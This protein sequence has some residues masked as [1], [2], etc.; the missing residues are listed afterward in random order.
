M[1]LDNLRKY[2]IILASNSPRRK[3]LLGGLGIDYEVKV[4]PG[5]D[6]SY[7]DSLKGEEIPV[8]IAS[9]KAAAYRAVMQEN[10][11]IITADTIVYLDGE[12]LGKP[13][14]AADAARMLRLLSGKTHQVITGVCIT[15]QAFQKSFAAVTEV[16]FDTLSE[17]EI[18]YYVSKYA[19]MDKAGSYGI[20][21]WIGFIGVTGMKGSYFNVMGLPVQRLYRELKGL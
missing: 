3:E 15:T 6:E 16:T 18:D 13:C 10:D 17:E 20:Q 7:P 12:V 21:E 19:P 2:R 4:L 1:V 14:D 11:L 8:Y 5:I 9:E